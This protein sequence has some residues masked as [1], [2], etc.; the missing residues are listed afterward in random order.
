MNAASYVSSLFDLT[1][2]TGIITGAS[3]GIGA[4]TAEVLARAGAHVYN[5]S[6]SKMEESVEGAEGKV[7]DL[8]GDV[9]DTDAFQ[10]AL[11]EVISREGQLDFLINN[12]GISGKYPAEEFPEERLDRILETDLKAP[13]LLSRMAYPYLKKSAYTGRIINIASMAAYMGFSGVMPY[14]MAKS[15]ILGL[16]R[17]LAE[18]WKEDNVLV[19]A[20]SPGWIQT[21][22]NEGFFRENPDRKAA[23]L[24][25]PML[26]RFGESREIGYMILFLLSGA[27]L[28]ITGQDFAVDGGARS[29]GF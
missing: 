29:H 6:R 22:L 2:H 17:G 7:L 10:K 9:C 28:Y 11:E 26:K 3:R 19:N 8:P 14:N 24:S 5:Y 15:G 27:S 4:G 13:F 12:A 25:K 23:A 21:R 1:G 20:V 16:T 18:E